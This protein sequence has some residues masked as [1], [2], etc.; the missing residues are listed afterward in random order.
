MK[1]RLYYTLPDVKPDKIQV[2]DIVSFTDA[3]KALAA[4]AQGVIAKTKPLLYIIKGSDRDGPTGDYRNWLRYIEELS[5]KYSVPLVY[6]ND[7]F[8]VIRNNVNCIDGYILCDI[9]EGFD[10]VMY[11]NQYDVHSLNV[12]MSL[13]GLYKS[14]VVAPSLQDK[15]EALGLRL[16]A[17]VRGKNNEWLV[18]QPEYEKLSKDAVIETQLIYECRDYQIFNNMLSYINYENQHYPLRQKIFEDLNKETPIFGWPDTGASGGEDGATMPI[19]RTG[20]FWAGSHG[21]NYTI[22]GAFVDDAEIKQL[23]DPKTDVTAEDGCHYVTF[24]FTDGD[25][26]N[27]FLGGYNINYPGVND[28]RFSSEHRGDIDVGWG[29]PASA[30]LLAPD[31]MQG[32]YARASGIPGKPLAEGKKG[33]D[34][35]VTYDVGGYMYPFSYPED[36]LEAHAENLAEAMAKADTRIVAISDFNRYDQ[37]CLPVFD[38]F[39]K[40]AQVDGILYFDYVT[41]ATDADFILWSNGKPVVASR[42]MF[43]RNLPKADIP[44]LSNKINNLPRDIKNP[45][46]YSLIMCHFWSRTMEEVVSL[47]KSFAPHV[48][49]VTPD[50]FIKL[51]SENVDRSHVSE[52]KTGYF[53]RLSDVLDTGDYCPNQRVRLDKCTREAG[54]ALPYAT[55][56]NAPAGNAIATRYIFEPGG[57]ADI[58]IMNTNRIGKDADIEFALYNGKP[59]GGVLNITVRNPL[60][61]ALISEDIRLDTDGWRFFSFP[62]KMDGEEDRIAGYTL[63]Y[64]DSAGGT[65]GGGVSGGG[66][67]GGVSTGSTSV[68]EICMDEFVARSLSETWLHGKIIISPEELSLREGETAQLDYVFAK[69]AF[70]ETFNSGARFYKPVFKDEEIDDMKYEYS[71][72]GD[73]VNVTKEGQVAALKKGDAVINFN[74]KWNGWWVL[75][76]EAVVHVL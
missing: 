38:I 68:A 29:S 72:D 19:T 33:S 57:T 45:N 12:A 64:A 32:M 21:L 14:V 41:Y 31:A 49:V 40:H 5:V 71:T 4:S 56:A 52:R 47:A 2:M 1:N 62:V 24:M 7:I 73:A 74:G 39:T 22:F 25:S 54:C 53:K 37:S 8:A 23:A 44:Y 18:G 34:R 11:Y 43:W 35:F 13:A 63:S 75:K 15:I 30:P 61:C 42:A 20:H 70:D 50:A 36:L 6:D 3:E 17:D 65:S 51:I 48:R 60:G 27:V 16:V 28:G 69:C 59:S 46:S 55:F 10:S 26:C 58:E 9:P 66:T 67:S 76:A